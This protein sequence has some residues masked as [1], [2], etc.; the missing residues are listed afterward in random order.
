MKWPA[1]VL[2]LAVLLLSAAVP[3]AIAARIDP[4][5]SCPD[6]FQRHAL[7]SH[8][9]DASHANQFG[10]GLI[11][12]RHISSADAALVSW[13]DDLPRLSGRFTIVVVV[14]A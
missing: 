4:A 14:G 3:L 11:C 6:G 13:E 10:I 5:G 8:G 12:T 1:V 9:E 7:S 2:V